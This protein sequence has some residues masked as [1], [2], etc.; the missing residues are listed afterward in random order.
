MKL[1]LIEDCVPNYMM[2][3]LMLFPIHR[4]NDNRSPDRVYKPDGKQ[5][6]QAPQAPQLEPPIQ[7][8]S[9]K[10]ASREHR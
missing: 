3:Y 1:K 10:D 6:T 8:S 4:M 5:E 9:D 2:H 7:Q